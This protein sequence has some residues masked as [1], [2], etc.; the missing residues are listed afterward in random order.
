MVLHISIPSM[1]EME[2]S[3]DLGLGKFQASM[4]YIEQQ[5]LKTKQGKQS[6]LK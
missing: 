3:L 1:W 5:C 2:V 6:M 4:G